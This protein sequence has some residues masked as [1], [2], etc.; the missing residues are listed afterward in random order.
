MARLVFNPGDTFTIGAPSSATDVYG[1]SGKDTITIAAGANATLFGFDTADAISLGGNAGAYTAVRSGSSIV[2]TTASG[3]VTIPVS[4]SA[5]RRSPPPRP[6]L[7]R[8]QAALPLVR[9]SR[10]LLVWTSLASSRARLGQ[11]LRLALTPLK[12]S[13]RRLPRLITSMVALALTS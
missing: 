2:L 9:L 4:T 3:S 10:L 12:P 11:R 8:A 13:R 6:P 5:V 1:S 7:R